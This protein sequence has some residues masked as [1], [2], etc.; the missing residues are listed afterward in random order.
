[1][2]IKSS[3]KLKHVIFM[4]MFIVKKFTMK[5]LKLIFEIDLI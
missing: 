3:L 5:I 2:I 4:C 1:M